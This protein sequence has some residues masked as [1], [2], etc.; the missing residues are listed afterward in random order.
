MI[1]QLLKPYQWENQLGKYAK[2]PEWPKNLGQNGKRPYL[3]G[4]GWLWWW[5]WWTT[6]LSRS[7][8]LEKTY[9]IA[10][11]VINACSVISEFKR[12]WYLRNMSGNIQLFL[13]ALAAL[14]LPLLLT[15]TLTDCVGLHILFQHSLH[16]LCQTIPNQPKPT[17]PSQFR[18]NFTILTKF[19]NCDK[20]FT[21]LTKFH[22]FN[23]ISQFWP[24]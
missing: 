23:Q 9:T 6:Q 22:D 14:Y 24:N 13:A 5:W 20:N 7:L 2:Y 15:H 3:I 17:K 21:I 18:P 19:H 10:S 1:Y 11:T 4:W 12:T 8:V 16:I